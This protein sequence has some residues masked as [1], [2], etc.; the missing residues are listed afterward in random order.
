MKLGLRLDLYR[1]ADL[2]VPIDTVRRAEA[3]GYHSVWTAEAYGSDALSPLAYLAALT[4]RIKLATAVV[5]LAAAAT[6]DARHARH[7]DRRPGRRRPSH[8]RRRGIGAS[9]RRGLVR[10]A[11]GPTQPRLRDYVTIVRKVVEREGPVTH[12]GP[13]ISLPYRGPG[14]LGQG[15]ALQVDHASARP[16][17]DLAGSGGPTKHRA[18]RRAVRR[19]AADGPWPP[20]GRPTAT[21]RGASRTRGPGRSRSSR[22]ASCRDHRR[23]RR[24][25]GSHAS[26][27]RH[28]RRRHGKRDAQLSPRRHGPAGIPRGRATDPGAVAAGRRAGGR[29]RRCPTS[30]SSSLRWSDPWLASARRWEEGFVAARGDRARSSAR[31]TARGTRALAE[32]AGTRDEE[33]A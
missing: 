17:P 26:A 29:A 25:A 5:Q 21:T 2:S 28:V 31:R 20:G 15:K 3:L 32:L 22:A 33:A 24:D 7:D 13:E 1:A 18:V 27:H 14:A 30:T 12:D 19:L 10:P 4:R 8:H 11:V 6:C 9:D 23:R 16:D